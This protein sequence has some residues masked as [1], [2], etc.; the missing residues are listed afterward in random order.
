MVI[1]FAS[2][3][4]LP[5]S[6]INNFAVTLHPPLQCLTKVKRAHARELNKLAD[7]SIDQ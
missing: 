4:Q 6:K 2:A 1:D 3:Y 5:W 7:R